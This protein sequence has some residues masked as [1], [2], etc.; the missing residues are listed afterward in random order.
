MKT[1]LRCKIEKP[2][3]N[4]YNEALRK[5]KKS[6]YCKDCHRERKRL[7]KLTNPE[8]ISAQKHASY[9]RN[10]GTKKRYDKL[11]HAMHKEKKNAQ[12]AIWKNNNR[13]RY[14]QRCKMLHKRHRIN[15]EDEYIKTRLMEKAIAMKR[16]DIPQELIELK[17]LTILIKRMVKDANKTM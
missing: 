13:D 17:R 11:Y 1:C 6:P 15:L 3:D 16:E 5:D 2:L 12:S 7:A 8:K 9:L 10:I 14:N 4:F